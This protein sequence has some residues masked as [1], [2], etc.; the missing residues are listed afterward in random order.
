MVTALLLPLALLLVSPA[1]QET[2]PPAPE[3]SELAP[4]AFPD[5]TVDVA[6]LLGPA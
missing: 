5:V 1:T 2:S 3:P 6:A 4:Q